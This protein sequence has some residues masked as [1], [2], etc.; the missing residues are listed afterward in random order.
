M[1]PI[2]KILLLSLLIAA[3]I[4]AQDDIILISQVQGAPDNADYPDSPYE[5]SEVTIEGIVVGDFQDGDDGFHGD[6]NGFY[7]QEEDADADDN[8]LSSEGIY[9]FERRGTITNVEI[10]DLVRVSGKVDEIR[11]LTQIEAFEVTVVSAN[12]PLPE[13]TIVQLPLVDRSDLEYTENMLVTVMDV[14]EPLTVNDSYDLGRYGLIQLSAQGRVYQYTQLYAPSDAVTFDAYREAIGLGIILVDDGRTNENAVPVPTF[15]NALF[16][17]DNTVRSGYTVDS[18]TGILEFRFD[19]WRIQPT[20][21]ITMTITDNQRPSENP[22]L[23]GSLRVASVNLLNYF[24][25]TGD[26]N[27]FPTPR[28]ADN[29]D[30]FERQ[31]SKTLAALVQLD[32][33]IIGL[34]ELENDYRDGTLSAAQD[35]VNGMNDL[36]ALTR[37]GANWAYV[38]VNQAPLNLE[39]LGTD[40]IAVGFM[41]CTATTMIAPDTVPAILSD[42]MLP[43]LGL[44]ALIPTFNGVNTNRIPL[45]VT[46]REL[47]TD[48]DIT[49]VVNHLKAKGGDGV[50]LNADIGDGVASWNQRRRDAVTA[51]NRWLL[52]Y[53]TG[54]SDSDVLLIG[55]FNAYA[56]ED[57]IQDLAILGYDNLLDTTAHSYGFPLA[58]GVSPE[59][60]AWG[61]LDYAFANQSLQ[62]QITGAAVWHINADEPIYIDYNLEYKPED[63]QADLYR[64]DGYRASDHDPVVVGLSLGSE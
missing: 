27:G 26:G 35:L 9:V 46:F 20:E 2:L 49:I 58:L 10:G 44:A 63:I 4:T 24:N 38:D 50:G 61:T 16:S 13:S 1:R 53:P 37:C 12:N 57:P 45:A 3:P 33:D 29:F 30:E 25:G 22:N 14:D 18:V 42:D 21:A 28:G 39:L 41:Y 52:T 15:N 11:S 43:D 32:A 36:G 60:Q 8:L 51:L 5:D 23:G 59:T 55:D 40:A 17:A 7:L 48:E 19:E 54:T 62:A 47:A 56:M 34:I 64:P 6:I 31:R